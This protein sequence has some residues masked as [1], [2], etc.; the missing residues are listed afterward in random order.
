MVTTALAD[1]KNISV[2]VAVLSTLASYGGV[3]GFWWVLAAF[4]S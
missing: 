2:I 3:F 4:R 1:L